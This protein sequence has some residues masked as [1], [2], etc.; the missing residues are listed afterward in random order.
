MFLV[1][2]IYPCSMFAGTRVV[3]LLHPQPQ[4][5]N[6]CIWWRWQASWRLLWATRLYSSTALIPAKTLLVAWY[7]AQRHL[8]ICCSATEKQVKIPPRLGFF[9]T[10]TGVWVW[11]VQKD[12]NT[13]ME[14]NS[15]QS[16][17]MDTG[18]PSLVCCHQNTLI[19]GRHCDG[20]ALVCALP[21]RHSGC[22]TCASQH[23]HQ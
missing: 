10:V 23:S 21:P 12:W 6:R 11:K 14:T 7:A 16:S 1:M 3:S 13:F 2:I 20:T 19:D 4:A 5:T 15:A 18:S 17:F 9:C 22:V 8:T